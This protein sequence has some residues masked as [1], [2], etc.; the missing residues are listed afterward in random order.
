MKTSFL[1]MPKNK[2]VDQLHSNCVYRI[3]NKIF[4]SDIMHLSQAILK[5]MTRCLYVTESLKF[6]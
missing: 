2:G 4:K 3:I 5:S 6:Y 1:Q